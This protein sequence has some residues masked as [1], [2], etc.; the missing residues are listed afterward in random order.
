MKLFVSDHHRVPLPPG[1][2]FP[3][4]KY[5]LL[6]RELLARG[7]VTEADLVRAEPEDLP[8]AAVT[9]VHD[10]AYVS[11]FLE[12]A[13]DERAMRRI[14]FPW[15]PALVRRTLA[16]A[17]G[18][19]GAAFQALD[20]GVSG[21]LAGGTHHAHAGHGSGYCVLN[22]LAIAARALLDA[23]AARRVLVVDLDVHQGDGTAAIFAAEERVFTLSIHGARNFP[24]RKQEGDLDVELPDGTGDDAYLAA[25]DAALE[26]A[27]A[28]RP[29]VVFY[30]AGVDPLAADRL[31]RLALTPGGLRLR[32]VRVV[33]AAAHLGAPLVVT[34]GG[35]YAE[36]LE[37]SV[38]AHAT[39]Y[40]VA[41]AA[42]IL[43]PR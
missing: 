6:R 14:G 36:P 13:L 31:G 12:G 23:G 26:R 17:R 37:A 35:G 39:T 33:S 28:F 16:S 41:A 29:D 43:A 7:V 2:R 32:D 40:E 8:L 4:D 19:L 9:A 42:A 25:L 10:A 24:F 5:A 30:Q 21:N 38:A 18:T 11:A 34:M 27:L 1:H 22:D 3:M 20:D 15:S